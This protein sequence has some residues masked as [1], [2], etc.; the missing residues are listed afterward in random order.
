MDREVY[1]VDSTLQFCIKYPSN[2][3]PASQ[4]T[5]VLSSRIR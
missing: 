5:I 3:S 2:Q 4:L 1:I